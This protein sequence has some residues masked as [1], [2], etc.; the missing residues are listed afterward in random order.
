[1]ESEV[2]AMNNA[3]QNVNKVRLSQKIDM[4]SDTDFKNQLGS[5][6]NTPVK[7]QSIE[8]NNED[9]RNVNNNELSQD[10]ENFVPKLHYQEPGYGN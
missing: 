8:I 2:T 5:M 4:N 10:L 3:I 7:N 6:D 9:F 1:M